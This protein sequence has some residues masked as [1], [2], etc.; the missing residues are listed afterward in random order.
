M[1]SAGPGAA[2]GAILLYGAYGF[3]GD[4]TARLAR[5]RGVELILAGRNG[6]KTAALA[7]ELGFE[8]RVFG[9]EDAAA[10]L[11]GVAVVLHCAGPFSK[12]AK[13]MIAACIERGVHYLDITGEI[14][15]FELAAHYGPKAAAAGVMLLPGVGFDVVP[16]DCL[17]AHVH[18]ALPEATALE[19]AFHGLGGFSHGTASTFLQHLGEGGAI[20]KDGKITVVPTAHAS[21][22]IDF[23]RGPRNAVAIP[24]GDVSTAYHSTGIGNIVVYMAMPKGMHRAAK[25][26]NLVG[27]ILRKPWFRRTLQAR[28]DAGPA[29][30][31]E[32]ARARSGSYLWAEAR[33]PDGRV[34]TARLK[35]PDGYDLT[36]DS[37]LRIAVAVCDGAAKP[38]FQTPSTAF[39]ADF[40]L[41]CD[42]VSRED[43]VVTT[44]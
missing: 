33:A 30:P 28:L 6:E 23:G 2:P 14:G 13:P 18:A 7:N 8:H 11:G 15:V 1:S 5:Q 19:L 41:Q 42:G 39:G 32:A 22:Q 17:A 27:P 26:S 10:H 3:T 25:A 36:A 35:T 21:R 29:G 16:S 31:D 4:L 40:V 9:L 38:G 12:T 44:G 34:A 20:R 37:S 43:A 24:W